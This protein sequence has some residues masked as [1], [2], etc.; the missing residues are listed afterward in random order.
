MGQWREMVFGK[1]LKDKSMWE[2]GKLIELMAMVSIQL[3]V[4]IIKVTNN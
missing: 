4:A 3:K 1:T 2:N